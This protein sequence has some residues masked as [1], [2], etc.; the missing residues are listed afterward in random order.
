MA[1]TKVK[2]IEDTFK[3]TY[4]SAFKQLNYYIVNILSCLV[5]VKVN[6]SRTI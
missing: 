6:L 4:K 5:N 2:S 3:D 1:L